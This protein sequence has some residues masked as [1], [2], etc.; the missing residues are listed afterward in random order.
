MTDAPDPH[1]P[2][3]A[4]L[5]SLFVT[6]DPVPALVTEA[7]KAALGWRR[8]D[9]EL[10]ELLSDSAVQEDALALARGAGAPVRSVTFQAGGLTIEIEIHVD[11]E[12][13]TL[14]GQISPPAET[15]VEIERADDEAGV[16]AGAGV[17]ADR[18]GRFRARL[19]AGGP[20]RLIVG[21]D[22]GAGPVIATSW[23]AI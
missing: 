11:G 23:I 4:E 9:A 10:A 12:Q 21:G 19:A 1:E 15:R 22:A 8:L 2:L 18:L 14:L 16:A 7:A 3:V 20:I 13:R 17:A 6:A 5:R